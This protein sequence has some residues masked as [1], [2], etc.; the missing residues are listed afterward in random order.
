MA[1]MENPK[2]VGDRHSLKWIDTLRW[3]ASSAI[4]ARPRRAAEALVWRCLAGWFALS[5]AAAVICSELGT[6]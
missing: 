4:L 2:A 5:R 3:P 6:A 1:V